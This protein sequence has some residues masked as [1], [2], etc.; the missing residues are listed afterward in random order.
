MEHSYT[1]NYMAHHRTDQIPTP[2]FTT[3]WNTLTQII[4]WPLQIMSIPK[5]E[6]RTI[7]DT[8]IQVPKWPFTDPIRFTTIWNTLTQ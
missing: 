5:Q 1:G 7:L 3:I 4:T 8:L 2:E 6:I